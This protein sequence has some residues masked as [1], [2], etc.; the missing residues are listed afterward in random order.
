MMFRPPAGS[1]DASQFR[2]L[3]DELRDEGVKKKNHRPRGRSVAGQCINGLFH[4]VLLRLA[5]WGNLTF[6]REQR[7]FYPADRNRDLIYPRLA[8]P[9]R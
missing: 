7:S 9:I 1:T 6:P 2:I 4:L 8:E 5:R 3:F